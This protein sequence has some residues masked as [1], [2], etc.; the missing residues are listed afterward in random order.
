MLNRGNIGRVRPKLVTRDAGTDDRVVV[1]GGY[2][3]DVD[4]MNSDPFATSGL[5]RGEKSFR[6]DRPQ[7]ADEAPET[8]GKSVL[9][10]FRAWVSQRPED[11]RV[12][13]R[14]DTPPFA[15]WLGWCRGDDSFFANHAR[16]VNISRGGAQLRVFGPPPEH[17]TVW[18]CL[19]DPNSNECLEATVLDVRTV[20]GDECT[21]HLAFHEPCSHRFFETA[22]CL[23]DAPATSDPRPFSAGG[24]PGSR[25]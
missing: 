10:L 12:M 25:S 1:T 5:R 18:I 2:R 9:D 23:L 22:V 17:S 15:V 13:P 3:R 7:A 19:G 21:I 24:E 11:R 4:E 20:R 16:M 14:H 8:A 6:L